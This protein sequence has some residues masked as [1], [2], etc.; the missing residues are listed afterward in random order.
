MRKKRNWRERAEHREKEF[1]RTFVWGIVVA[2]L[3]AYIFLAFVTYQFRHPELTDTQR[4][5]NIWEA[6]TW[7]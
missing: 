3:T 7:Q 1:K 2:V 5:L 6:L 4:F